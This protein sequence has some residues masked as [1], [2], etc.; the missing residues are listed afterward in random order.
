M[1]II[2]PVLAFMLLPLVFIGIGY[3]LDYKHD[4][5][6]FIGTL[7]NMARELLKLAAVTAVLAIGGKFIYQLF[8]LGDD[9]GRNYNT[10]RTE[11]GIPLIEPEWKLAEHI[12][13]RYEKWWMDSTD[14]DRRIHTLKI[15]NYN[16][17]GPT[18]ELDYFSTP[19]GSFRLESHYDYQSNSIKYSIIKPKAGAFFNFAAAQ[20]YPDEVISPIKKEEFERILEEW[21]P[22]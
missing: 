20:P 12:G 10:V 18:Q 2:L 1:A 14:T 13:S 6:D 8:P 7:K 3:Y 22:R 9:H 5:S 15:I 19:N 11:A 4:K 21:Q 16:L 17:L